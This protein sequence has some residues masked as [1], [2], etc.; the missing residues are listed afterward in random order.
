MKNKLPALFGIAAPIVYLFTVVLGGILR[1]GYNHLHQAISELIETGA[2][3]KA[4]LDGCF[5]LY[6]ALVLLAALGLMLLLRQTPKQNR[7][8][9]AAMILLAL[10][11]LAG[12]MM[13]LAFPSDVL[14]T[15]MTARGL[16]HI[17]LAGEESLCSMAAI[18]LTGLW[19][20]KQTGMRSMAIYSFVSLAVVFCSGLYSAFSVNQPFMGLFER[21][22]IGTFVLWILVVFT[23]FYSFD[24]KPLNAFPEN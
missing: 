10:T 7:L 19:F 15:A 12:V 1:P 24:F 4:L 20:K 17:I 16:G 18:L 3:N 13:S 9:K 14:G 21:I 8:L 6:N 2:P 23:R 22:T 5:L 11:G